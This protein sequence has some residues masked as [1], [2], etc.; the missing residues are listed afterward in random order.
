MDVRRA[1]DY[2]TTSGLPCS[3]WNFPLERRELGGPRL[4]RIEPFCSYLS[5]IEVLNCPD[6][7]E[8]LNERPW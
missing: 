4:Q 3:A 8:S 1:L 7:S 2:V 6:G 5:S